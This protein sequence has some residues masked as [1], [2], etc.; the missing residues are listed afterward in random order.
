[1]PIR[2]AAVVMVLSFMCRLAPAQSQPADDTTGVNGTRLAIVAGTAA[3]GVTAIHLYQQN[4]WWNEHRTSFHFREDLV[5]ACNIDKVGHVYGAQVITFLFSKSLQWANLSEASSLM[6]GASA[7]TLFQTY[8]E[9]EDGFSEYWG[10]DRVDFAADVAGAWYP[11][12]QHYVPPMKNVQ[13]RFSYAPKDAGGPSAIAGQTKT[14]IDD[15]EGQTFWVT[16]TPHSWL[17]EGKR[18]WPSFLGVAVGVAVR[19]NASP[20]RYLAW[21]LAPELDFRYIIPRD[22]EFLRI[23]GEALNFLHLPMPA[24]RVGPGSLVWY[25]LYF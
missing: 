23:L 11:V 8:V 3:A 2:T 1:M 19:N 12:L 16:F 20:D 25:G 4:A 17:P 18:W 14:I 21:Y 5:Y 6:W 7:A 15:Y 9:I 24:V 10:F 13:L 22:T